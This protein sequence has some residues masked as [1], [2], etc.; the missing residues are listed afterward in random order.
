FIKSFAGSH[1]FVLDYL[2]EEVLGK[3]PE[4]IQT[5][6]HHTSLLN[7]LCGS[8]CDAV[9]LDPSIS[10]QEILE[11]LERANLFIVPLD[12]DRHWYRYHQLFGDVLRIHLMADQP[13]Q[14]S[15]LHQR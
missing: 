1:R 3:Q 15:S 2:V 5:F 14:A 12:N 10:G 7:R 13:E 9:M 4:N 8:L 6:L 11:K